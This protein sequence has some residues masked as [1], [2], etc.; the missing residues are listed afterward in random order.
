MLMITSFSVQT[1]SNS[2]SNG[3][4]EVASVNQLASIFYPT[5]LDLIPIP[6]S[7]QEANASQTWC[8][9]MQEELYALEQ[10]TTLDFVQLPPAKKTIGCMWVHS[11]GEARILAERG[12]NDS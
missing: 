5:M 7:Y 9:A 11:S 1:S 3:D 6:S 4:P 8:D 10:N 12:N 2:S